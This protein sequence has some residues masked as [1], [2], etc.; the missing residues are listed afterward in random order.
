[1]HKFIIG[2]MI[3]CCFGWSQESWEKYQQPNENHE[4]LSF[5]VGSWKIEGKTYDSKGQVASTVVGK[6]HA[7]WILEKRFVKITNQFED[8]V[9]VA[10]FGHDNYKKKYVAAFCDTKG[11]GIHH[12]EG[13][14]QEDGSIALTGNGISYFSGEK[15][16]AKYIFQK[17]ENGYTLSVSNTE[18]KTPIFEGSYSALDEKAEVTIATDNKKLPSKEEIEGWKS[19][20]SPGEHH[21]ALSKFVGTWRSYVRAYDDAGNPNQVF[22]GQAK[23]KWILGDRF[24][25]L[26]DDLKKITVYGIIGYDNRA[27]KYVS[28]FYNKNSTG[29]HITQGTYDEDEEQIAFVGD[30]ID[31]STGESQTVTQAYQFLGD[32]K[33]QFETY[34]EADKEDLD[35]NKFVVKYRRIQEK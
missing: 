27:K 7:D 15:V 29:I 28:V 25:H 31:Y 1:M 2:L 8:Y 34:D 11:T 33:L 19:Y 14:K 26:K 35:L 4:Q 10:V 3:C 16:A 5:L 12:W 22:L 17:T 32:D 6:S 23:A 30:T 24:I 21:K 13:T 9:S 18:T 20:A